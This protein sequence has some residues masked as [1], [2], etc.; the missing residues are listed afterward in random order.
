M[1]L[2]RHYATARVLC[3]SPFRVHLFAF[4]F[5]SLH[6]SLETIIDIVGQKPLDF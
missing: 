2:P 5:Q 3:R 1:D 4:T 6:T